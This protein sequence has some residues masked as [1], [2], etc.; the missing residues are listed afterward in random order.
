VWMRPSSSKICGTVV[1]LEM[2]RRRYH[3]GEN[4][5]AGAR[6]QTRSPST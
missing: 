5:N 6:Q 4:P 3:H 2:Y 1:G